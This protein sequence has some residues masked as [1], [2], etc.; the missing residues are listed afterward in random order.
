MKPGATIYVH[1]PSFLPFHI[2]V[3]M[4]KWRHVLRLGGRKTDRKAIRWNHTEKVIALSLA[5]WRK[6]FYETW[7]NPVY[8][9][10]RI[11]MSCSARAKGVEMTPLL[12]YLQEHP[13]HH[14]KV[15]RVDLDQETIDELE[16][17]AIF[18]CFEDHR[19]YQKEMFIK[20]LARIATLGLYDERKTSDGT[21]YCFEIVRSF[22]ELA[23]LRK[24]ETGLV[25][26]FDHW[27][28]P[29]F[30]DYSEPIKIT[31]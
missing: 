1:S 17:W 28:N 25:D 2:R 23:G 31:V 3:H 21:F 9:N 18:Y 22:D 26:I 27:E 12:I 10:G 20:W 6:Y 8:I 5:N 14:I 15:P 16:R 30:T 4:A 13:D 7:G 29:N 19:E 11:L 24:M